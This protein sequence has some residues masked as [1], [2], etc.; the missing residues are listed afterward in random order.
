MGFKPRVG[1]MGLETPVP[2]ATLVASCLC[3]KAGKDIKTPVLATWPGSEGLLL[4]RWSHARKVPSE[5][6][7]GSHG[8]LQRT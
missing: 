6:T 5:T 2:V 1:Q 3:P 8:G 4:C 7:E